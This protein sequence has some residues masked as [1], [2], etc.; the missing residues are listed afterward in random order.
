M[1][2]YVINKTFKNQ[3][4]CD[5]WEEQNCP[6]RTFMGECVF[7]IMHSEHFGNNSITIDEIITC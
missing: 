6:N 1:K 2:T 4:E 5:K 7:M 3:N